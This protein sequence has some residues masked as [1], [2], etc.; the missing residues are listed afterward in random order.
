MQ[1][2]KLDLLHESLWI[3]NVK[4][5]HWPL[6]KVTQIEH[7]QTSFPQKTLGRLKPYFMWSL[8]RM[9]EWKW[10]QMVYVTWPRWPPCPYMITNCQN[11]LWNR[12]ADELETWY[13]ASSTRVLPNL[14]KWCPWVDI[15]L[16]Y[17]KFKFGPH[18]FCMGKKGKQWIFQKIL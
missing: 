11:F 18:C 14:F 10:V 15:D 4:V 12:E 7:F 17:G 5:I 16:F 3:S 13:A 9:E 6:S 8:H 2:T 1:S